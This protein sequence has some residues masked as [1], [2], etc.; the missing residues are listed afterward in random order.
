LLY[1]QSNLSI[2]FM[3]QESS[4]YSQIQLLEPDQKKEV[5]EIAKEQWKLLQNPARNQHRVLEDQLRYQTELAHQQVSQFQDAT[6]SI[7]SASETNQQ[8]QDIDRTY[9]L[10]K[11]QAQVHRLQKRIESVLAGYGTKGDIIDDTP[12]W[13]NEADNIPQQ[14]TKELREEN[15]VEE[16]A[17]SLFQNL[18]AAEV[19]ILI[20]DGKRGLPTTLKFTE[21]GK[22]LP[23]PKV[24]VKP[25]E[26]APFEQSVRKVRDLQEKDEWLVRFIKN[27]SNYSLIIF[28]EKNAQK[29]V[30]VSRF[31]FTKQ[32]IGKQVCDLLQ[33]Q[34]S[35]QLKALTN[36]LYDRLRDQ[37]RV[38]K[39]Q[40]DN[41]ESI[42]TLAPETPLKVEEPTVLQEFMNKMDKI[43]SVEEKYASLL[44]EI[45]ESTD[46]LYWS[47]KLALGNLDFDFNK[48]D[49]LVRNEE[50][51]FGFFSIDRNG[52]FIDSRTVPASA[53][54]DKG[55][56]ELLMRN[57]PQEDLLPGRKGVEGLD[58]TKANLLRKRIADQLEMSIQK[59]L[60]GESFIS[61]SRPQWGVD[62]ADGIPFSIG[63][64]LSDE[65]SNKILIAVREQPLLAHVISKKFLPNSYIENLRIH[66]PN[67]VRIADLRQT[68]KEWQETKVD[69]DI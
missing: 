62:R 45:Q 18:E 55:E 36:N 41:K 19:I 50:S 1:L 53:F 61:F 21:E 2:L 48:N 66:F 37:I 49:I 23:Q 27:G 6:E 51:D 7:N 5:E 39:G 26:R 31:T 60:R 15:I 42:V 63:L 57:N 40:E 34:D 20:E 64:F 11:E 68:S 28:G 69:W 38:E 30:L 52:T 47:G 12:D 8:I 13:L 44:S 9:N 46:K 17:E 4:I 32:E 65:L 14:E 24:E 56:I 58:S 35:D 67:I 25:F 3:T 29:G 43:H 22:R 54:S 33:Q 10:S 59:N 16:L